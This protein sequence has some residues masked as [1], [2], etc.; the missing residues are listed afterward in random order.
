MTVRITLTKETGPKLMEGRCL[1]SN[2]AWSHIRS[3]IQ[4]EELLV[5]DTFH[6]LDIKAKNTSHNM[7]EPLDNQSYKKRKSRADHRVS[8]QRREEGGRER[9]H[10]RR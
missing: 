6:C 5:E 1:K 7:L 10:N 9:K 4:I 2:P 3:F 8:D